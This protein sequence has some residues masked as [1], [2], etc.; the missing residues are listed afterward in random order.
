VVASEATEPKTI[1]RVIP[2][3]DNLMRSMQAIAAIRELFEKKNASKY[4]RFGGLA[5]AASQ[6]PPKKAPIRGGLP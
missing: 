5:F 2:P 6:R 4:H 3:Y 1:F